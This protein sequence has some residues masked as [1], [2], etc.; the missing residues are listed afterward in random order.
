MAKLRGEAVDMTRG[1]IPRLIVR[2]AAPMMLGFI[3]QQLFQMADSAVVGRLLGVNAFAGVGAT[4]TMCWLMLC[5]P[6]GLTQGFGVLF[7][8]A[9]GARDEGRL[10]RLVYNAALLAGAIA[11][12]QTALGLLLA[13]WMLAAVGT[14]PEASAHALAYL[15]AY[16]AGVPVYMLY[17]LCACALRA[18][19]DSKTPL[20]AVIAASVLNIALDVLAVTAL[21]M[22]VAGVA[23]STVL[24]QLGA[25]LVCLAR[26]RKYPGVFPSRD[27]MRASAKSMR[28]LW[29]FGAPPA[30]RNAVIT[31]GGLLVLPV[32]NGYGV[33]FVAGASAAHK[34]YGFMEMAGGALEAGVAT[35]VS[36]NV[37]AGDGERARRGIRWATRMALAASACIGAVIFFFGEPLISVLVAGS[38]EE[39]ASVA[40]FGF[41]YLRGM[42]VCLP[43]LYLLFVFRASLQSMGRT[44]APMLS[45]FMEMAF[46]LGSV[47]LLSGLLGKWSV[48]LSEGF[49]WLA[50]AALLICAY[51]RAV[52]KK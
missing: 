9:F 1:D 18:V 21:S 6:L 16:V 14:P 23:I 37:G 52:R 7:A 42:A 26:L 47:Y 11:L 50:A 15:R 30:L 29:R 5:I 12:T 20:Y 25:A 46:K 13:E 45:G 49:G 2:F 24:S 43:A 4:G 3:C 40:R 33:L 10:K 48:Y 39:L 22:G 28:A 17:N 51:L 36:Q 27:A 8:Q 31:L 34:Y 35:F 32:V 41:D 38:Q 44:L 19:G